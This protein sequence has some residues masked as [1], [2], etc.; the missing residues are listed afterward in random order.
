MIK[1]VFSCES[2]FF[3][4]RALQK[5]QISHS[6]EKPHHCEHCNRHFKSKE[7]LTRHLDI[8]NNSVNIC[9]VCGDKL[10][11]KETLRV[12]MAIHSD[13]MPYKCKHPSCGAAFKHLKSL[14]VLNPFRFLSFFYL[15]IV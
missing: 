7:G 2:R 3:R 5:H 8:H 15:F 12:H 9:P 6:D 11:S 4:K 14:K 13:Q 1:F 10:R